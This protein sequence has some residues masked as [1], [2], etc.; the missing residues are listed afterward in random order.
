MEYRGAMRPATNKKKVSRRAEITRPRPQLAPTSTTK[1]DAV[2]AK[3]TDV[4]SQDIKEQETKELTTS[5]STPAVLIFSSP[6]GG[7]I[8]S[9]G[10]LAASLP[11]YTTIG[12]QRTVTLT[13][14]ELSSIV[15]GMTLIPAPGANKYIYI[16]T[17]SVYL[18]AGTVA[19]DGGN[20]FIRYAPSTQT[21]YD[22]DLVANMIG[23]TEDLAAAYSWNDSLAAAYNA[24][25]IVNSSIRLSGNFNSTVGNGTIT[26]MV[27]Y[28]TYTVPS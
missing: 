5:V 6:P 21:A 25:D 9:N 23:S 17:V 10:P 3:K 15:S 26:L 12:S 22:T 28:L 13:L 18:K 14:Q 24:S 4:E 11:Q 8:D 1:I 19:F 27:N 20:Y 16:Q 2:G 7:Q